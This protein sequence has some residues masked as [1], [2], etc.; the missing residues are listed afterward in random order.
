[1]RRAKR[2]ASIAVGVLSLTLFAGACGSSGTNSS[3]KNTGSASNTGTAGASSSGTASGNGTG[4]SKAGEFLGINGGGTPKYGGTLQLL[5]DGDVQHL[6]PNTSYY[7]VDY[8][9]DRLFSR[10]LYTYPAK[11]GGTTTLVPDLATAL[12][13]IT[14]GGKTYTVT[15]RKGAMW[16]TSPPR[17]V[18]G[19][20]FIRGVKRSCNPTQPF[21]GSPDFNTVLAGYQSFCNGFAKVSSTSAA[22]Q[23][24]YIDS[25]QIS[26][27]TAS[28][29]TIT[30]HLTQP[31]TYFAD[32][33]AFPA[34]SPAPVEYLNYLP[35]SAA[36]AQHTISDGPYKVAAYSATKYIHFVR[37]PAWKASADPISKAYVNKIDVVETDSQQSIE[38]Q[39]STNTLDAMEWNS[40]PPT[41]DLPNLI[42]T[43]NPDFTLLPT[44]GMVPYFVFNTAA[45]P[46]KSLKVR[47]ALEYALN[48]YDFQQNYGGPT[49]NPALTQVLPNGIGGASPAINPY[50]HSLSKAKALL[51]SAGVGHIKLTFLYASNIPQNGSDFS[52]M[53]SNLAKVGITVKGLGTPQANLFSKYMEVPSTA[54]NDTWDIAD[55][56][57]VPDWYGNA[58]KSFFTPLFY[59][60]ILPP[61]SNDDG[62]FN[63]A[64]VNTDIEKALTATTVSAA[65]ADWH[66]ADVA[67]MA[68]A[69]IFPVAQPY[70]P[71][72]HSSLVHNA[73]YVPDLDMYD[74]TNVWLSNG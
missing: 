43:K 53:Q 62:L 48:R 8:L 46:L 33:L 22:A 73:I 67:T 66:S 60:K 59:G 32:I 72:L 55:V 23:K 69:P 52:T 42:A 35:G 39:I 51:K 45:G 9:A 64:T 26:G 7:T 41:A 27:I 57:W 61:V 63:D 11:E 24:A 30:I 20:D 54:K 2:K 37:N 38:Q 17:Q 71:L 6:D 65:D 3:T 44:Y 21:G 31:A 12:P 5:G 29:L 47:Q 49:V 56:A 15:I 36:I 19:A 40:F 25:H 10:Q 34:L 68:Q 58:A 70:Q 4:N 74:P 14:D 18:T 13:T 16:D 50:P 28:G 1:M